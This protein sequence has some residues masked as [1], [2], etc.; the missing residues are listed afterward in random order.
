M[1][2]SMSTSIAISANFVDLSNHA[3]VLGEVEANPEDE[4]AADLLK[5]IKSAD[6]S[7]SMASKQTDLKFEDFKK[8]PRDDNTVYD[9]TE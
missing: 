5:Q 3:L 8:W 2:Q 6:F 7:T 4:R 1:V 9:I